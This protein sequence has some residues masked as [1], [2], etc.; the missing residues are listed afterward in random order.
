[1]D[2]DDSL[3]GSNGKEGYEADEKEYW[4]SER[5][6]PLR[7]HAV[8][9]TNTAAAL[10]SPEPVPVRQVPNHTRKSSYSLFPGNNNS[11]VSAKPPSRLLPATYDPEVKETMAASSMLK[12]P[13]PIH[14]FR[15]RRDSSL[16]SHTTVQIGLRLSNV[17][18]MPPVDPKYLPDGSQVHNLECPHVM[19]KNSTGQTP[20]R[21][22]PLMNVMMR[23]AVG[24]DDG[25]ATLNSEYAS[26]VSDAETATTSHD[27]AGECKICTL[28]PAVYQPPGSVRAAPRTKL[29]S[30]KGVGFSIPVSRS[31]SVKGREAP[32]PRHVEQ[33]VPV[34]KA[35]WI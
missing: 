26:T 22:S 24:S 7:S 13:A 19:A 28:A 31:G 6:N 25:S 11:A 12:P 17:D 18:D 2:T 3:A 34:K 15:H 23:S 21:P 5:V 20:K 29:T 4:G 35:D 14:G 32:P 9:P 33:T 1:M 27:E 8:F 10:R 30:P 16:A